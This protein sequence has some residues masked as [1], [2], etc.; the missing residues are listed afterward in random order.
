MSFTPVEIRHVRLGRGMAG[1]KRAPV[2]RLLTEIAD[3][4]EAVWRERADLAEK[5]ER[6]EEDLVRHRELDQLLRTTLVSAERA[7]HQVKDQANRE[8]ETIL[9]EAR[10][11][12]REITRQAHA[13]R[14]TLLADARRIRSLLRSALDAIPDAAPPEP[15]ARSGDTKEHEQIGEPWAA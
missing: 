2:D 6:L 9:A 3:S 15:G 12:A 13:E 4:F 5:V 11:E 8:A 7:A 10:V 1:Y 14:E